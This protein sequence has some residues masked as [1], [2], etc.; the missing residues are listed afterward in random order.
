MIVAF[1]N[2]ILTLVFDPKADPTPNP[3]TGKPVSHCALRLEALI[4]EL[5]ARGDRIVIP[6]PCLSEMLCSAPDAAKALQIIDESTAF[7]VEPFDHK[8]AIDLAE[9]VTRAIKDGK[10]K[11]GTEL[12]WQQVKHDRQISMIAKVNRAQIL[13]TDDPGQTIFAQEIG[14]RVRHTWDL[15]LPLA[16]AQTDIERDIAGE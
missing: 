13:Y 15:E 2:S 10:K 1:D 16:Y 7:S 8:C 11:R 4:D 6:A 3:A 5:S 9:V 14:L 12:G